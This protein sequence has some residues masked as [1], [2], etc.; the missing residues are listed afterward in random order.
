M[1]TDESGILAKSVA[2][3]QSIMEQKARART[4]EAGCYP[5][6][7]GSEC[8]RPGRP[9]VRSAE[10]QLLLRSGVVGFIG[11]CSN[12]LLPEDC[13][14]LLDCNL[15]RADRIVSNY[16]ETLNGADGMSSVRALLMIPEGQV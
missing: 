9:D 3:L 11:T 6:S 2:L 16:L 15:P 4:W 10:V 8:I 14:R 12:D 7:N 5:I 1:T 13:L